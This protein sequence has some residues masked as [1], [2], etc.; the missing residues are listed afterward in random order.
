MKQTK[1]TLFITAIA[2]I[3][4]IA[5]GIC[6]EES[7]PYEVLNS[8][9]MSSPNLTET[10]ITLVIHTILPIDKEALAKEI[11]EDH[12]RLNGDR[13]NQYVELELYRTGLHYRLDKVYDTLL[14]NEAGDIVTEVEF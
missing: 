8:T 6:I 13:P 7:R 2:I 12:M 3:L 11:V 5:I 4:L 14:C 1:K 9:V 10:E